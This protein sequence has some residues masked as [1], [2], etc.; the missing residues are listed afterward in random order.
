MQHGAQKNA[1]CH[2]N[3]HE[4]CRG[5]EPLAGLDRPAAPQDLTR[6]IGRRLPTHAHSFEGFSAKNR[7]FDPCHEKS[8]AAEAFI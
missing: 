7:S 4:S 2:C 1:N 3:M 8:S 6:N 5:H